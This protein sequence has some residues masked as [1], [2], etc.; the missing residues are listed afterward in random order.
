MSAV[1]A[2]VCSAGLL[3]G[4]SLV[5][6]GLRPARRSARRSV[7]SRLSALVPTVGASDEAGL[8]LAGITVR[9]YIAQRLGGALVGAVSGLVI[10]AATRAG[11]LGA[12]LWTVAAGAGGWFLP[13]FGARDAA[14]KARDEFDQVVWVWIALVAQQ[15][16]AGADPSAAMLNAAG[17]GRRPMWG[18][19]RRFL[20]AAQHQRR[21]AWE[22]LASA[23]D[24][25]GLHSLAPTVSALGLAARRGTRVADAVLAAA[26]NL[27]RESVSRQRERA[28]RRSQIIVVPATGV[29]LALAAILV[30]PPFTAL[31]GGG[32]AGTP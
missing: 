21:P 25:Y 3:V 24:R 22:G 19:L 26:D 27:W 11:T 15:V 30:Y 2:L 29:A 31:T 5:V 1:L 18:V 14:R 28:A 12:V 20:L 16:R 13:V 9:E 8:R 6:G 7:R 17:A 23:V 10:A 32:L 4:A